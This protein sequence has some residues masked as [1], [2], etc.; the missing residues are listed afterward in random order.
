VDEHS[1]NQ[2]NAAGQYAPQRAHDESVRTA[3]DC[4]SVEE[5]TKKQA[6][7]PY[8]PLQSRH[9]GKDLLNPGFGAQRQIHSHGVCAIHQPNTSNELKQPYK[10]T[11][12]IPGQ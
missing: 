7:M 4:V 11:T 2:W 8:Q 3:V 10:A 6:T 1:G 5:A 12:K 9:S